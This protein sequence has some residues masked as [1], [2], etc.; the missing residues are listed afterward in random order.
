MKKL[1]IATVLATTVATPAF[2]QYLPRFTGPGLN[3]VIYNGRI[4]GQD[5]DANVRLDLIKN[6][7]YYSGGAT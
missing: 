1:I 7:E 3:A 5:P 2:A 4:I 6:G